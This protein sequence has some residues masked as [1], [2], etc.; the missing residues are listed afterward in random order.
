MSLFNFNVIGAHNGVCKDRLLQRLAAQGIST[1]L[2]HWIDTFCS[3][4]LATIVVN[5]R[6]SR[7]SLSKLNCHKAL[8]CHRS[9]CSFNA[10]L[11]QL[12]I[13][14]KGGAIAFVDGYTV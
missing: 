11:V 4:R 13:D 12:R 1:E 5:G 2:V 7:A 14:Q 3:E 8:P 10:D 9:F 6:K